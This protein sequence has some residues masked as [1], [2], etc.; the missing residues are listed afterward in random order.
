MSLAMVTA[1]GSAAFDLSALDPLA[2]G[3]AAGSDGETSGPGEGC[4]AALLDA[5]AGPKDEHIDESPGAMGDSYAWLPSITPRWPDAP[6]SPAPGVPVPE[7]LSDGN[8]ARVDG[9]GALRLSAG[10]RGVPT[11]VLPTPVSRISDAAGHAPLP[12]SPVVEEYEEYIEAAGRQPRAPHATSGS[13]ESPDTSSHVP[14]GEQVADRRTAAERAGHA[15]TART[16]S[17]DGMPFD[18]GEVSTAGE[19]TPF[20]EATALPR[21][22][23]TS[24]GATRATVPVAPT[25]DGVRDGDTSP[26]QERQPGRGDQPTDGNPP[27]TAAPRILPEGSWSRV[28]EPPFAQAAQALPPPQ[29]DRASGTVPLPATQ[30][31]ADTSERIVQ[32]IRL[33]YQR[34]AGEAVVNL[35]PEHLGPVSIALRVE[36][37]LVSVVVSARH[38]GVSEWLRS[39]E[40]SL[41]EGLES[42]GLRLERFIVQR[43]GQP[44]DRPR[45]DWAEAQRRVRTRRLLQAHSTFDITM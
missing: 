28:A 16:Q 44:S 40:Q 9:G 39:N 14:F 18:A 8:G 5:R 31:A 43:D 7:T 4:F 3:E 26:S 30:P 13:D 20:E 15:T 12:A 19:R 36:G 33:Q 38:D 17:T 34:G 35:K 23:P 11:N 21:R 37:G 2:A 24:D 25:A 22:A 32:S 6:D 42:S 27:V 29:A 1:E 10:E 41:R 45:R